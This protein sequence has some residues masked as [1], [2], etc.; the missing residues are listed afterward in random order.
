[1]SELG[2]ALAPS[3]F[4]PAR[5]TGFGGFAL[6]V[7]ASFA[8]INADAVDAT[9]TQYWHAGTQGPVDPSTHQF[10][11]VNKN[12]DSFLRNLCARRP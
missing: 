7:E 3:A 10:S 4:H 5:T 6:S 11:V 9:G 1:M 12:P 2:Y 8:H